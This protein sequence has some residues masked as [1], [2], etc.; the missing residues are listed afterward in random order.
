VTL[1]WH[2]LDRYGRAIADVPLD[3]LDVNAEQV[4]RGM[5]LVYVQYLRLHVLVSCLTLPSW[6]SKT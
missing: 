3:G 6:S 2:R 4:K 1:E 5:A